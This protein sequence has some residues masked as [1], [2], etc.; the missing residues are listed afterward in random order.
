MTDLFY[1][2]ECSSTQDEIEKILPVDHNS[3]KAVYTFNQTQ[4]KGQYGNS[5]DSGENKN[6]AYSLAIP[7]ELIKIQF[8]LF[9]FH[10]AE[11]V[12]DFLANMTKK[13]VEIK[14]PNDLIIHHKKVAGLLIE[15]KKIDGISFFVIGLGL[16]VLANKTEHLPKAGS[17]WTQTG[18]SFDLKNLTEELHKYLGLHLTANVSES[19]VI[20][21]LNQNLFRKDMISVFEIGQVRQNGI[22][23]KVDD[24]GYLWV[25]LENGGLKKFFHKEI[26]LLY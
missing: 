10:T 16:N 21:K 7:T 15:K 9:N 12:A 4:G 20:E 3:L 14:W 22:I 13:R 23:R 1:L 11:V 19:S 24:E 6:L 8:H 18:I 25:E 2:Q 26:S 17:L 5:W